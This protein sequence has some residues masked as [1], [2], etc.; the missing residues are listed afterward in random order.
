MR[1]RLSLLF[2]ILC[3]LYGATVLAGPRLVVWQKSGKK[4]FFEL[5]EEPHTTFEQ[6]KLII[7]TLS[8][9]TEYSQKDVLRYTFEGSETSISTPS[10]TDTGFT[11]KGDDIYVHGIPSGTVVQLYNLNGILLKDHKADGQSPIHFSL[12]NHPSGTYIVKVGDQALK[13]MKR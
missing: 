12:A 5:A 4:V 8:M 1:K 9:R 7:S 3:S 2:F 13:F 10:P 11:Q 6:G